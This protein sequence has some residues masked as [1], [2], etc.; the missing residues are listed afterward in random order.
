MFADGKF[1]FQLAA[2]N[3]QNESSKTS[4]CRWVPVPT[5][6]QQ[7]KNSVKSMSQWSQ[8]N[9][10]IWPYLI[11]NNGSDN[12]SSKSP[13]PIQASLPFTPIITSTANVGSIGAVVVTTSNII[14]K[15]SRKCSTVASE[16]N[17]SWQLQSQLP[18]VSRRS[19]HQHQSFMMVATKPIKALRYLK[20]SLI[21]KRQRSRRTKTNGK[22]SLLQEEAPVDLEC[23]VR[24][25]WCQQHT[26]ELLL[27]KHLLLN[28]SV[29]ITGVSTS[30]HVGV[31][32]C[33][34]DSTISNI[35]S[36]KRR[37]IFS[38]S[39][40]STE[41]ILPATTITMATSSLSING[42]NSNSRSSNSNI[43]N[44]P[45]KKYRLEQQ[46]Q[47]RA[48]SNN[49]TKKTAVLQLPTINDHSITAILSGGA[50]GA[51]RFG[52]SIVNSKSC[53]TTSNADIAILHKNHLTPSPAPLSLLRTLLKSPV[54][55]NNAQ[56]ILANTDDGGYN[57][58]N[59]GS[60]RK[61]LA[62]EST[63]GP[64]IHDVMSSLH[65]NVGG[66]AVV[67]ATVKNNGKTSSMVMPS[68]SAAT[69]AG[70]NAA[71][72]NDIPTA[73]H[74]LPMLHHPTTTS[75]AA[76]ASAAARQL[77]A[78]SY[79]NVLYHQA[80]MAAALAYQNNTQLPQTLLK[81]IL[82]SQF[83]TTVANDGGWLRQMNQ[84]PHLHQPE[85]VVG[86]AT[87]ALPTLPIVAPFSSPLVTTA[88][89]GISL[90]PPTSSSPP[91]PVDI[92]NLLQNRQQYHLQKPYP[93]ATIQQQPFSYQHKQRQHSNIKRKTDMI[94]ETAEYGTADENNLSMDKEASSSTG[95]CTKLNG[96]VLL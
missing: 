84:R 61:R 87:A 11:N 71:A 65:T 9:K 27:R 33:N 20:S 57:F 15:P 26:K 5:V 50:V 54:G 64:P 76:A 51:K 75:T 88:V 10:I 90:L 30:R 52:S 39:C 28:N 38:L 81:P 47:R 42:S 69:V 63:N 92:H 19:Q 86:T 59:T 14:R 2:H 16:Y 21:Y 4:P 56:P 85:L 55:E 18:S 29:D 53:A 62:I 91:Q 31:T 68:K 6:L 96:Y 80:A 17:T 83:S 94:V 73:N 37:S 74:Q 95:K 24:H 44:S 72:V 77:T 82:P 43:N 70:G 46:Q 35:G 36:G 8:L 45:H 34:V 93:V 23:I 58:Y 78:A 67:D 79:F 40:S 48:G 3:Q 7:N 1:I 66:A 12:K 89:D 25:L 60:S 32:A 41:D 22:K 13:K 49:D